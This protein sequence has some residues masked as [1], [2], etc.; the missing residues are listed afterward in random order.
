MLIPRPVMVDASV[1]YIRL[2]NQVKEN[3][4]TTSHY[5]RAM[6]HVAVAS[7]EGLP[8]IEPWEWM[9]YSGSRL[10]RVSWGYADNRGYIYQ[11][12]GIGAAMS[13][14][15]HLQCTA[16][17]RLDIQ[18]TLWFGAEQADL[19]KKVADRS[20]AARVGCYGRPY[21]VRLIDGYGAGDTAYIGTRGKRSKF[22]RCYDKYME[23]DQHP[24][25]LNAWRF[26]A[27][28]TDNHAAY[29]YGTLLD[30]SF[31]YEAIVAM[32]RAYWVERGI[33]LPSIEGCQHYQASKFMRDLSSDARRMKWLEEQVRPS[34]DK[35]LARGVSYAAI[36]KAL[37]IRPEL[38]LTGEM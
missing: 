22:L 27:E 14:L 23:S 17:P 16:V 35:M 2:T 3:A 28:L 21:K 5:V 12:T 13:D 36:L 10:G 8:P 38:P 7:L 4:E 9:G 20:A 1:D 11:A 29:A 26:E 24:S 33:Y 34:I 30:Q 19:A 15:L 6:E 37:G 32:V 25:Y 18:V 31:Q